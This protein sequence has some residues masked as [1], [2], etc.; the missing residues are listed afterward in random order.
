MKDAQ[1]LK[2]TQTEK[3]L[4]AA[5]AGE[6]QARNRYSY[7]AEIAKSEGLE[8]AEK[9]FAQTAKNEMFHAKNWYKILRGGIMPNVFECLE[10]AIAGENHEHTNM[11]PEFAET[12]EKEGFAQIAMLFREIA[13]IEKTH[14]DKLQKLMSDL[15]NS[16]YVFELESDMYCMACGYDFRERDGLDVC[17]VCGKSDQFA[18]KM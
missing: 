15:K 3:N 18:A 10:E 13:K 1:F 2:G 5:F 7:Y 17:P 12:A 11:Y 16:S 6:S 8:D 9:F 4:A 14:E